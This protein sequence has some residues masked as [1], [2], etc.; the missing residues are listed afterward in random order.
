MLAGP[1]APAVARKYGPQLNPP[2]NVKD[3]NGITIAPGVLGRDDHTA[4]DGVN[5]EPSIM[6]GGEDFWNLA[7]ECTRL[8]EEAT[9]ERHRE[10]FFKMAKVWT[11][12]ARQER[13]VRVDC[14]EIGY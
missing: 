6:A 3:N 10:A 14:D 11:R 7:R 5:P 9:T 8:A 12:L 2:I 4:F 1:I 13:E